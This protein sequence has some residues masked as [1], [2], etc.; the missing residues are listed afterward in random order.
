MT[1]DDVARR[2]LAAQHLARPRLADPAAVVAALGA[3]QAQDYPAAK[4]ALGQRTTGAT[5]ADVERA[6]A[7]GAILRTHVLRPTWH[8]VAPTDI[9]WMLALT[10]PRVHQANAGRYRELE[11]DD[12]T[13][14]RA[15][16]VLG[17]ALADGAHR[18]R[19]ELAAALRRARI[20][21]AGQRM[22][23]LLMHAELNAVICSG[24]RRGKQFTYALLDTR[25]PGAARAL[26]RDE[27]LARLATLYFGARGPATAHDF[28]WWSGLTIADARR[29]AGAAGLAAEL[30]DGRTH[31]MSDAPMTRATR[32][33]TAHLL[34]NYDELFVGFRDRSAALDR[35]ASV[36]RAAAT[37][38]VMR[39]VVE[40][41][42]EIVGGWTRT[43][44]RSA[45]V[46]ALD[47]LAPLTDAERGAVEAAVR[48]YGTFL[49]QRAVVA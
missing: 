12:A 18:T 39:H 9:R 4:W 34:P 11:L 45:V 6:F 3:V 48:R 37:T 1:A 38:S 46:V 15:D 30:I 25:A 13:R 31:W 24:A 8:F 29:G 43:L 17:R 35:V 41:G 44:G 10:G 21:P 40:I 5:D 27:A 42:G 36:A 19:T 26:D 28:A 7:D 16:A 22:A 32:R 14:R 20:D 49:G 47:L 2:R 23:H 33:P